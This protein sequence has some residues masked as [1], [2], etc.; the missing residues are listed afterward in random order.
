LISTG[1]QFISMGLLAEMLARTYH[2]SQDKPI[3][4]RTTLG[5]GTSPRGPHPREQR[6]LGLG[7]ACPARVRA[8]PARRKLRWAAGIAACAW[9]HSVSGCGIWGPSAWWATEAPGAG[10][11]GI[12]K[13]GFPLVGRHD[14][15]ARRS[16]PLHQALAAALGG[17]AL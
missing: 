13:Y 5:F 9:S 11:A 1:I 10:V 3:V 2:E 17:G 15:S 14:L 8:P 7:F 12:A 16:L 6:S 4:V